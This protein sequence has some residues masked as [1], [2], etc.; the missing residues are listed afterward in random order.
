MRLLDAG[1]E[2][3]E[4]S[5]ED[6]ERLQTWIDLN[7]PYY[8]SYASAHPGSLAGRAPLGD[9]EVRRL[10]QLTGVDLF[11]SADHRKRPG[12][13]VSFDRPELSPCLVGLEP[14][15]EAWREAVGI[16]CLGAQELVVRPEAD[17]PGFVPSEMDCWREEKYESRR[18]EELQRRRV[19]RAGGR[20][21]DLGVAGVR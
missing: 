18:R 13:Q 10:E 15:G 21:Y 11:G 20:V 5:L 7:G 1:H 3:V 14:G 4:L 2:G 19:I 8:P 6:M 9:I 12:P 17:H 16:I